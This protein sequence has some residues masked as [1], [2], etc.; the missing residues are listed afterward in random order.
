MR[1]IAVFDQNAESYDDWFLQNEFILQSELAAI[2]ELLPEGEG[3]EIGV[4]TGL[5][6]SALGIKVGVEP[7]PAMAARA[8]ARGIEVYQGV[9]EGLPIADQRYDFALMVTVDC[10]LR[11]VTAAFREV[12]RILVESGFFVIALIDR[13]TPLGKMYEKKRSESAFYCH[14]TFHSAQESKG[15]LEATGFRIQ[16]ARQ[17]IFSLENVRQPVEEGT[18]K[19]VFA[20]I[21]AQKT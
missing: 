21:K 10:F 14:A 12:H 20:V 4:G 13:D 1:N 3:I 18:G 15:L 17:T 5:F 8:Q 9:A 19:G 7:A 16:A 2:R 11:D 6:A